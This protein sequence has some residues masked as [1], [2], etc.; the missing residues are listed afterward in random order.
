MRDDNP[1]I[2]DSRIVRL[3]MRLDERARLQAASVLDRLGVEVLGA[4]EARGVPERA[5]RLSYVLLLRGA[6]AVLPVAFGDIEAMRA[7]FGTACRARHGCEAD[8]SVLMIE[9]A[10]VDGEGE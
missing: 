7:A 9:A 8:V 5:V 6:E 2:R 10:R 1:P 4:M 3:E